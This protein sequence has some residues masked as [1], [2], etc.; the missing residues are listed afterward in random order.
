M[1]PKIKWLKQMSTSLDFE[2]YDKIKHLA[3]KLDRSESYIIRKIITDN[4]DDFISKNNL[5]NP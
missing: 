1:S 2:T 3:K 4:L 5:D